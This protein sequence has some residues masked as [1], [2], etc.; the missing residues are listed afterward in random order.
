MLPFFDADF[1][2]A[3]IT[4]KVHIHIKKKYIDNDDYNFDKINR[5]SKACGNLVKWVQAQ[6]AFA[7]MVWD[8]KKKEKDYRDKMEKLAQ[9]DSK[10]QKLVMDV[11]TAFNSTV[12]SK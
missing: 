12:P 1:D 8:Y 7:P 6:Y 2:T 10:H 5:G 11:L 9:R 3:G 4:P